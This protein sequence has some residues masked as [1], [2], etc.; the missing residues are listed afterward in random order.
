MTLVELSFRLQAPLD[1]KLT[2]ALARVNSIYGIRH[3]KVAPS[4]DSIL[5]EYDASRLQPP[6][7]EAVLRRAGIDVVP[8]ELAV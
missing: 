5:V 4:L 6:Q 7:V 3:V 2:D 1:E 8:L